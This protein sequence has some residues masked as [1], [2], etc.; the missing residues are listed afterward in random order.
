MHFSKLLQNGVDR[1]RHYGGVGALFEVIQGTN[2]KAI[3]VALSILGNI[4]M[5]PKVQKH[6]RPV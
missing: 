4:C 6:V 1:L 2:R 5:D 3:D